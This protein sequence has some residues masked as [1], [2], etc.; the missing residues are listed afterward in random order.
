MRMVGQVYLLELVFLG[1]LVLAGFSCLPIKLLRCE[2][3]EMGQ[4]IF[5][6]VSCERL[7]AIAGSESPRAR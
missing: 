1:L 3:R 4:S 7:F 6:Y 5:P 2:L